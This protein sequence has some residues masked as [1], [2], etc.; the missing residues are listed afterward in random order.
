[1]VH[2]EYEKQDMPLGDCISGIKWQSLSLVEIFV[3]VPFN[4]KSIRWFLIMWAINTREMK[5]DPGEMQS[6]SFFSL[7]K[8]NQNEN[9]CL[10]FGNE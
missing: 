1:V 5:S 10:T 8:A 6:L 9:V 7:P 3:L 2:E 4:S